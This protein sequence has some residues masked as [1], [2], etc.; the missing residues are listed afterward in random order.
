MS[1]YTIAFQWNVTMMML[2]LSEA[3]AEE[4]YM[5]TCRE[6]EIKGNATLVLYLFPI[7]HF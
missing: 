5:K 2:M 6:M 4:N 1:R 7:T 3:S